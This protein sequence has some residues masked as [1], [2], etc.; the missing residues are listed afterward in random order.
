MTHPTSTGRARTVRLCA[1][2]FDDS[3]AADIRR[4]ATASAIQRKQTQ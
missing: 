2:A 3:A 1:A 4:A